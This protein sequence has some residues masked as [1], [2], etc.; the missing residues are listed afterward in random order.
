MNNDRPDSLLSGNR[1]L[2]KTDIWGGGLHK[3]EGF[4]K[5]QA[6]IKGNHVL[7]KRLTV[8]IESCR[9]HSN[10]GVSNRVMSRAF[11]LWRKQSSHVVSIRM[12]QVIYIC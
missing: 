1:F 9:E 7:K 8:N 10:D 6:I 2:T 4:S 12:I 3:R 5:T 11:E